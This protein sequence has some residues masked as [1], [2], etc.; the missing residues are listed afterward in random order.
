MKLFK[1]F[2]NLFTKRKEEKVSAADVTFN[3]MKDKLLD[4]PSQTRVVD[5]VKMLPNMPQDPK[6][7][8]ARLKYEKTDILEDISLS[9]LSPEAQLEIAEV[10]K[11]HRVNSI[12]D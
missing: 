4:N 8:A 3:Y 11:K 6:E 9:S 1:F 10:I 5:V 12:N 7:L 2:S